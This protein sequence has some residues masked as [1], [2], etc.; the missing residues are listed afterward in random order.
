MKSFTEFI[1]EGRGGKPK[2]SDEY[3]NINFY[4]HLIGSLDKK[5]S[6]GKEMRKAIEDKDNET[7]SKLIDQELDNAKK[8]PKHPLH[9]DNEFR[10]RLHL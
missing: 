10:K 5:G 8:D 9:F 4:N 1:I 2:Y 3:A 7:I 6:I